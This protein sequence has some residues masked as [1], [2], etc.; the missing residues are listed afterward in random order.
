MDQPDTLQ[1]IDMT[2]IEALR[3]LGGNE[4]PNLVV[5]LID[6]YLLDAPERIR[7]IEEA[8]DSHDF[9]LLERASHTLKS[10][11]ANIGAA[12][13]SALCSELEGMARSQQV[14]DPTAQS[15][16]SRKSFAQVHQALT[17]IRG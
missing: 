8:L 4:D 10:A 6:L 12:Q 1:I 5:E 2:I 13:L 11:S 17:E 9:D 15:E 3:D 16:L 7:E 14:A